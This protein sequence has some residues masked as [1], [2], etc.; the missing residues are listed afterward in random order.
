[1]AAGGRVYKYTDGVNVVVHGQPAIWHL[2]LMPS[3]GI[4]GLSPLTYGARTM[5]IAAAAENRVST[6]A[7]NGFKP[8][9]V[10]MIDRVLSPEQREGIRTEF[11]DLQEGQGDPLRVL[12]AGMKFQQITIAPKDAQLLESRRFSVEDV[13]RFLGVP[14]VL[15]N[16]TSATTV[17]GSGIEQIKEGFYTLGIRPILERI[18]S[19]VSKWLIPDSERDTLAVEFDFSAF[20]RGNEASRVDLLTK[21]IAGNLKTINEARA[22]EGLS[23]VPNG[24]VMYAQSQ[25]I[26][27]GSQ[28]QVQTNDEP[29]TP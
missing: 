28:P 2:M 14:S 16:D 21:A 18:E 24:D 27:I 5:G 3:N 13:C 23:P 12:E 6:L 19:S 15:V 29:P 17:W 20:L 26:P 4:V 10:L 7:T 9:G 11:A 25:M 1:V 8:T 22:L